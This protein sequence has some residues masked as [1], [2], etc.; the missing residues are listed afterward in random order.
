MRK[1]NI[2]ELLRAKSPHSHWNGSPGPLFSFLFVIASCPEFLDHWGSPLTSSVPPVPST[3]IPTGKFFKCPRT[4]QK[5]MTKWRACQ[6]L[7][8]LVWWLKNWLFNWISI[9]KCYVTSV[10]WSDVNGAVVKTWQQFRDL[11]MYECAIIRSPRRKAGRKKEL[12]TWL[13]L[14]G[15]RKM[16]RY[17]YWKTWPPTGTVF[18]M[19]T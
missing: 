2:L 13:L 9:W 15:R 11:L 4:A 8:S 17:K 6:C 18:K 10:T 5:K 1:K 19:F 16:I 7:G 3:V 14:I 12:T